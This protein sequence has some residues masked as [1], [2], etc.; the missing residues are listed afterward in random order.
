MK[1]ENYPKI[2]EYL[3]KQTNRN[4]HLLLGNGFSMAYDSTIFSYNS[5]NAY[6]KQKGDEILRNL[7]SVTDNTNFELLM[8]QLEAFIRFA[9]VF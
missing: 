5:L 9:E 3:K 4:I 1:L 8:K 6:V 2:I 7:L